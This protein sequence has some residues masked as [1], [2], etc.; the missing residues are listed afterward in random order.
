MRNW[1][2][3]QMVIHFSR[4]VLVAWCDTCSGSNTTKTYDT[5]IYDRRV[6][7]VS[8]DIQAHINRT[9]TRIK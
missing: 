4:I 1:H 2:R 9:E 5:T 8:V 7:M 3:S 6:N